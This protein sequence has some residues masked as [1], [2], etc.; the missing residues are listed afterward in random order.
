MLTPFHPA[1]C[2]VVALVLCARLAAWGAE[3]G[4]IRLPLP[5]TDSGKPLMEAL[6]ERKS[7]REFRAEPLSIEL[8][9]SLLWAG[10]GINRPQ[11]DHRTAPSAMNS[12]EI[13][14]YVFTT[15]GVFLYEAKSHCLQRVSAADQRA[16]TGGQEFVKTAPVA[17]VF[18]ADLSRLAKAPA[19]DRERYA[20]IDAGYISQNIYLF[21]ASTGLGTV[22]HELNRA[23][24][25]EILQLKPNQVVIL[26]QS[27]GW[28]KPS[29]AEP[30]SK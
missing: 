16:R 26:A 29:A 18:V 10:F 14:L 15:D 20:W 3:A 28:P 7:V 4:A 2:G 6:R 19:A 25:K 13:D 24:L 1:R 12:Q 22:V 23:P 27:V 21:C 5:Q 11:I 9:S 8:L 17:L 30:A